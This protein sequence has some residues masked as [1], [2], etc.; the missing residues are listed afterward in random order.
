MWGQYVPVTQRKLNMKRFLSKRKKNGLKV[1]PVELEGRTIARS[2]WGKAWCDHLE[3]YADYR[4]RLPRGRTYVRNGSV[5][6]LEIGPGRVSAVVAGSRTYEISVSISK[7]ANSD[8]KSVKSRCTG[9]I[10]SV[11]ELLQ[12]KLSDEVMAVVTDRERGLFPQP[13]EIRM[14]CSCP[15]WAGMCK[16]VSAVLYGI[17]SRLDR[18]P[19]DLFV[20]RG[21]DHEELIS[22]DIELPTAAAT[23]DALA[24]DDL[25]AIFGVDIEGDGEEPGRAVTAPAPASETP[26]VRKKE[27]KS[28]SARPADPETGTGAMPRHLTAD[29]INQLRTRLHLSPEEFAEELGVSEGTVHRWLS[30]SHPLNL[31]N[32]TRKAVHHLHERTLP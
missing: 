5:G 7:L 11:L 19:E 1:R 3:S 24:G 8:W 27:R 16:H 10:G 14:T 12:G 29:W 13:D 6:H 9:Q 23:A 20:L 21:V 15:D 25:S 18:S 4:N 31:H 22:S 32:R 30:S 17:G 2:F 28:A 26:V